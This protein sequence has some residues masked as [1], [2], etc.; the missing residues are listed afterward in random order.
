VK[1]L[2]RL[3][4]A[5]LVLLA[6]VSHEATAG[7]NGCTNDGTL[8]PMGDE[9]ITVSSTSIGFTTGT[10]APTGSGPAV[11]ATFVVETNGVRYRDNGLAPTS[12]VGIPM[13]ATSAWNVCGVTT[14]KRARFIRQTADATVSVSYYRQGDN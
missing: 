9:Q 8:V 12:S 10:F 4:L 2:C 7:P 3:I 5:G 6:V 13:A 1:H 14:I 11:L